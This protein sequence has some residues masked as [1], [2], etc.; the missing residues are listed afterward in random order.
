M[1]LLVPDLPV[2]KTSLRFIRIEERHKIEKPFYFSGTLGREEEHL[3]SNYELEAN[4]DISSFDL[5]NHEYLLKLEDNGFE[6][7]AL[8]FDFNTHTL[9]GST[10]GVDGYISALSEWATQRF[11]AEAVLC[12]DYRVRL[13]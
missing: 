3:R 8:P 1:S 5:R 10:E 4:D 12:Y 9:K 13:L 11:D 6:L 7:Q 2:V